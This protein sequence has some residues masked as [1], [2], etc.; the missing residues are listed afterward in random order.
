MKTNNNKSCIC[1]GCK[2]V[3]TIVGIIV[4]VIIGIMFALGYTPLIVTGI[5]IAFS[6]ASFV[7]LYILGTLFLGSCSGSCGI[8]MGC[9]RRNLGCLLTGSIGT[10]LTSLAALSIVLDIAVNSIVLLVGLGAFFFTFLIV[11][12]ISFIKCAVNF[13]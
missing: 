13:D 8:I 11:G 5:W 6:L 1:G 10:I 12:I 4:G 2:L 3:G 7:L 9:I